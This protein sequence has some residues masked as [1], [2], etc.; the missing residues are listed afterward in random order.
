MIS[1][2]KMQDTN[3]LNVNQKVNINVGEVHKKEELVHYGEETVNKTD[4]DK[5]LSQNQALHLVLDMMKNNPVKYNGYIIADDVKLLSFV[6]LLTGAED[7]QLD[8]EELGE[9]CCTGNIY[10]KVAAIYVIFDGT[11]KNLKYDCPDV[12]KELKDLGISTKYVW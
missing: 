1:L 8:A 2:S 5:L 11:V 12:V 3:T 6:K 7:V 4:Y 10:R 9:G